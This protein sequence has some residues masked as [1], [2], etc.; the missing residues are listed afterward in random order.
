M[1]KVAAGS[2]VDHSL[3]R[4][5]GN[6]MQFRR[7]VAATAIS[8]A[9][10]LTPAAAFAYGAEDYSNT[11]K[12]SATTVAAG[13]PVTVTI[14]GPAN[15]DVTLTVTTEPASAPDNGIT[16]AG[17][18]SL[19]KKTDASGQVTFTVTITAGSRATLVAYDT[20]SGARLSTQTLTVTG[21]TGTAAGGTRLAQTGSNALPIGLGAG[22]LVLIGAGAVVVTSRRRAAQQA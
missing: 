10:V 22:A 16:I 1:T 12:V 18:K 2:P 20:A 17:T 4:Y 14:N 13:N 6:T 7:V 9:L 19:T 3:H 11:G 5:W 15:A 21:G 8:A